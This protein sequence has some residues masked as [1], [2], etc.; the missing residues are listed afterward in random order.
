MLARLTN[1]NQGFTL[2]ELLIVIVIIGI[3]A[4]IIVPGLASGP[5]RARDAQRKADMRS[6]K[7]ALETYY[8]DQTAGGKYPNI[9]STVGI[10][11]DYTAFNCNAACTAGTD[12]KGV[13]VTSY[14]PSMPTDAKNSGV[15]K[16]E[17]AQ[18]DTTA[19]S[20]IVMACLE[21]LKD[22]AVGATAGYATPFAT[23]A[24]GGSAVQ[25]AIQTV[26]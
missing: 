16:Y 20:A 13:L 25:Y 7:N 10:T 21:N 3:L 17:Y 15:F 11:D 22:T 14:L 24:C 5:Q 9:V 4:V 26:N 8:N 18:K 2:L 1:R 19:T 12:L 6:I 23:T